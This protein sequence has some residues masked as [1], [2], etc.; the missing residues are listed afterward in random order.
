MKLF[1][2]SLKPVLCQ[3]SAGR[4]IGAASVT[5]RCPNMDLRGYRS[6]VAVPA[7]IT[8]QRIG[9]F[10]CTFVFR[11]DDQGAF[12]RLAFIAECNYGG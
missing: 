1:L 12:D 9:E 4:Y 6:A 5:E 2:T 3:K 7:L 10:F 11:R 8:K